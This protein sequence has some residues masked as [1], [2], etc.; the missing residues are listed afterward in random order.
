[1]RPLFLRQYFYD[2]RWY[3]FSVVLLFVCAGLVAFFVPS[4]FSF[5]DPYLRELVQSTE[6]LTGF[7][8]FWFIVSNNVTVS[9]IAFI[10]G[11]FF[12]VLPVFFALSNG[13]IVGY[14]M[15]LVSEENAGSWLYLIPHGV[16][17][18]PAVFLSLALGLQLGVQVV[19]FFLAL[20][21]CGSFR[22]YKKNL[23]A[24]LRRGVFLF[25]CLIVPLLVVAGIIETWLI[26][27][28]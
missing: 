28:W 17:E 9:S 12:G 16:F 8:L 6:G 13:A 20:Y 1:M 27:A 21:G 25:C 15:R 24:V 26:V 4:L 2:L 18:L 10:G 3:L 23:L 19:H 5:F 11:L 22:M 7:A 14:V